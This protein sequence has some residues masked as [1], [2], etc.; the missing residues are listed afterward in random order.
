MIDKFIV[1]RRELAAAAVDSINAQYPEYLADIQSV[2]DGDGKTLKTIYWGAL[3]P[4]FLPVAYGSLP[5]W[6]HQEIALELQASVDYADR[7]LDSRYYTLL[8]VFED[9]CARPDL[10]SR[11]SNNNIIVQSPPTFEEC[12]ENIENGKYVTT[13]RLRVSVRG[14]AEGE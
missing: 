1:L 3:T 10:D 12:A 13:Y 2:V 4:S 11:L 6:T 14:R 8:K 7:S 5:Q 9:F